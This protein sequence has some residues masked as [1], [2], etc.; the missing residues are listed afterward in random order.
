[1][2]QLGTFDNERDAERLAAWLVA[3]RIDAQAEDAG[4]SEWAVWVRDEDQL[5]KAREALE[6]FRANPHDARYANAER[7][8]AELRRRE[9]AQRRDAQKNVVQMR[10]RWGNPA[11]GM[12]MGMGASPRRCPLVLTLIVAAFLVSIFTSFGEEQS[13]GLVDHL[14]FAAPAAVRTEMQV[15]APM[16]TNVLRGE[17]WRLVTPIF[18]HGDW[19]HLIM[20]VLVLYTFGGQIE[21]RRGTLYLAGL[22]LVLAVTSNLGQA[23]EATLREHFSRFGGLSGVGYGLFGYLLVKTKYDNREGYLLSPVTSFI[24]LLFFFLCIGGAFPPLNSVLPESLTH[25]ANSAHAVGLIVGAALA[26]APII[27]KKPA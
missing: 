16:W 25:V 7:D 10:N 17:V 8:A 24:L 22:A 6:H 27:L 9:E 26:Y 2:R 11:A 18:I 12:G 15:R 13:G 20:N 19:I 5:P 4:P 1:M 3:Q 23:V 21:N 14:W